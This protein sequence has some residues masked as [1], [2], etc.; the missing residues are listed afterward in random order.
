MDMLQVRVGQAVSEFL[1]DT[2]HKQ[3][4]PLSP[5]SSGAEAENGEHQTVEEENNCRQTDINQTEYPPDHGH[6]PSF[7]IHNPLVHFFQ[8]RPAHNNGRNSGKDSA[9]CQREDTQN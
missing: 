7:W 4:T 9:E 3:K 6:G 2:P 5:A 8:V 1:G